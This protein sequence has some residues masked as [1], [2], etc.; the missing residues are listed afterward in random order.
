MG[1]TH[2]SSTRRAEFLF[3]IN[4]DSGTTSLSE[5]KSLV[6]QVSRHS[7]ARIEV[8]DSAD[9]ASRLAREAMLSGTIVVA[10]GGDGFHNIVSQQAVETGGTMSVLP[11]GRGNDFAASLG[12]RTAQDTESAIRN[13]MIHHARYLTVQFSDYSRIS[14]TCAGVGLLSEAG[15]R[16]SRLPF[17]QGRLLYSV[18]ALISFLRLK[19]HRYTLSLDDHDL[20]KRL[21]MFIGAASEYTGGGICIAPDARAHPDK[22][23]FLYATRVGRVAAVRLLSMALSGKHLTHPKVVSSY[24]DRCRIDCESDSFWGSLVYGDGEHLGVLP[25]SIQIGTEPLRVLIPAKPG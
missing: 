25:A 19:C 15:Y 7:N 17:F 12:I 9:H 1:T 8:S 4:P 5:K 21:L 11:I 23:N 24:H 22:L 14:L 6:R 16:A 20:S 18:A 13:G 2:Q 3:L 10:C